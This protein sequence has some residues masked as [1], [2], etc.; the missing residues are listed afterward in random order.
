MTDTLYIAFS[1]T[2]D[3]GYCLGDQLVS[4][5]VARLWIAHYRPRRTIVSL[6]ADDRWRPL[7]EATLAL[8]GVEPEWEQ[9]DPNARLSGL[10]ALFD[11]RR[12]ARRTGGGQPFAVYRELYRRLDGGQRQAALC[13]GERGLGRKNIFEYFWCGQEGSPEPPPDRSTHRYP[14]G[15]VLGA[16]PAAERSGV[17]V[18]PWAKCQGNDVFTPAF[19]REVV[20]RLVAAGVPVTVNDGRGVFAIPGTDVVPEPADVARHVA[21]HRAVACGN[22]GIGWLAGALGVPLF[23]GEFPGFC[24]GDYR[25]E[26]CGVESLVRVYAAADAGHWAEQIANFYFGRPLAMKSLREWEPWVAEF[27]PTQ[28]RHA[29]DVG[30]NQGYWTHHLAGVSQRVTTFEPN[31]PLHAALVAMGLANVTVRREAAWL[32][33]ADV[34]FVVRTQDG[35][36][37]S[38]VACRDTHRGTQ[39]EIERIRVPAVAIDELELSEVDFLKIDVEGGELQVVMGATHTIERWRPRLLV[40]VHQEENLLW[41]EAWLRRAGYNTRLVHGPGYKPGGPGWAQHTWLF[42]RHYQDTGP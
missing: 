18:A 1:G 37:G 25:Y 9:F 3:R 13:G 31:P 6:V 5:H 32:H 35:A 16:V 4:I 38:A 15:E 26:E 2:Q 17:F 23:A 40:E 33:A 12:A 7:W 29:V 24:M 11:E 8:P 27:A 30:G 22:T 21:R 19:W 20:A 36:G 39:P 28:C 14:A 10:Y 41:L 34:E 42:A